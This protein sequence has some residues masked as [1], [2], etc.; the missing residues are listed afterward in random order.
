MDYD[1][2][3]RPSF[4]KLESEY[5][6]IYDLAI[7]FSDELK[8]QLNELILQKQITLAFPIE[9][10][11][12]TWT[13]LVT[14]LEG[15]SSDVKSVKE[16]SDLIGI[17]VILLFRSDLN[18]AYKILEENFKIIEREDTQRRLREN[19]FGYLSVHY[20]IEL[21]ESWF[22]IP[23]FASL[24][25]FKAEI[26]VRTAA[27]H[28]WAAASHKLQYKQ[29]VGVPIPVRR[30]IH[31]VSALLE[32]VDLE[33]DR[34]LDDRAEYIEQFNQVQNDDLL[35]VDLLIHILN[36]K[37]PSAN[38][39]DDEDYALLLE[40]LLQFGCDTITKLRSFLDNHLPAI[41]NLDAKIVRQIKQSGNRA[42]YHVD[43]IDR[44]NK[45]AFYTYAGLTRT[46]LELEFGEE[47]EKYIKGRIAIAAIKKVINGR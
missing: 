39:K 34:V 45:G 5:R 29:E 8:R 22:A 18:N 6:L 31:R 28:I 14:K 17:R 21:P 33:L 32:T 24:H 3:G 38:R 19:E 47:W 11:V 44:V 46:A 13:S 15:L 35:N 1:K 36:E 42:P 23:T 9:S 25:G 43:D 40:D 2:K 16:I 12:K 7:K 41:I 30:S 26:Q 20:I 10:R 27:Q 4:K 37:L